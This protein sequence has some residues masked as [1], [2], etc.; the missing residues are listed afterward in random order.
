MTPFT[1]AE[2]RLIWRIDAEARIPYAG[3]NISIYLAANNE[4][5]DKGFITVEM[6]HRRIHNATLTQAGV[7]LYTLARL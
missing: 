4:L 1:Q 3:M 6:R 5:I 7:N 2:I